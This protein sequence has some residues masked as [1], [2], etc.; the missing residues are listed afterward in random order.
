[1]AGRRQE[2]TG[3]ADEARRGAEA[4]DWSWVEASVWTERM[5]SAL[6]NGVKGGR[7]RLLRAGRAVRPVHG[8]AHREALPMRKPPTGEPY[9]GKPH[10][11]FGGRGGVTLPD[12]YQQASMEREI[13]EAD[14]IATLRFR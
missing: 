7:Q 2:S 5:V 1:M 14:W 13:V 8:L 10:V 9:A 12:P 3:S 4:R 11:R 6:D